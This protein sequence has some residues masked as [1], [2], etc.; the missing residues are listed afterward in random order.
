[1]S[2]KYQL[3]NGLTVILNESHKSPVVSVQMWV[4]TGSA[5]EGK[6]EEGISHFIE[7]LVFKGTEKFGVGEIASAVE[8]SGGELNA[9]TSFDQTVFYVTISKAFTDT[10]LEVISQMMGFPTFVQEEIDNEREVVIEEIKRGFDSAGRCSSQLLFSTAYKKHP[11]SIPV[12]GY[13]KNIRKVS[14]KTLLDYFHSRYVPQNMFLVVSGD[15]EKAE[16][17][18]KVKEYFGCFDQ[19]PLRRVK[20]KKE[21]VQESPRVAVQES[22]F[23]ESHVYLGWKLPTIKHKDMPALD[24]LALILGQGESSRL[25]RRL[26]LETPLVN[27]VYSSAF[28]TKEKGLFVVGAALNHKNLEEFFDILAEE[29]TR[30]CSESVSGQE[31]EKAVTNI[32]AEEFYGMETAEGLSRQLGNLEMLMGD[33]K[34]FPKYM[35]EVYGVTS[36]DV[37]KAAKKYLKIENLTLT[38]LASEGNKKEEVKK[39]ART[40]IKKLKKK[41]KSQKRKA[42]EKASKTKRKKRS[43]KS[44]Q[45]G[46]KEKME[47][48]KLSSGSTLVLKPSQETLCFSARSA[49]LGGA[50]IEQPETAGLTELLSRTWAAGTNLYSEKEIHHKMDDWASAMHAF[51]GRNTIGMSMDGLKTFEKELVELYANVLTQ[52]M[53]PEEI[54][55][56][57][58]T[59]MKEMIKVRDDNPAQKAI[60]KFMQELFL[61]HPYSRDPKGSIETLEGLDREKVVSHWKKMSMSSNFIT[62]V[63][64]NIDADLWKEK[65]GEVVKNLSP[66]EFE[67]KKFA[68]AA[69]AEDVFRYVPLEKQQTHI[70]TGVKGLTFESK[71]RHALDLI[72]ALLSGQGG[73]LFI[74]LRDKKSLAYSVSPLKMEGIDSGYFGAYIGCSPEKGTEAISMLHQELKKLATE[75]VPEKELLRSKR[76]LIGNHDIDLQRNSAIAN[77]ILFDE[78]YGLDINET[79]N[80]QKEI[81]EVTADQVRDLAEELFSQKFVTVAVGAEQPF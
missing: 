57:E 42:G 38:V 11:Y 33:H 6:G 81:N 66:G 60:L 69:P 29:V 17:K 76:Y 54:V 26:R 44:S 36:E 65:I 75:K 63:S 59:V 40:A 16:M 5:D 62:V 56:R 10:A 24:I 72:Q 64:G 4:R 74:E 78:I 7:H 15:F 28:K 12:I 18:K 68:H 47:V 21:D 48:I 70:V 3:P 9:Y 49:H 67:K 39:L 32:E 46:S 58:K 2:T 50:R 55:D 34:Y 43:F 52:P 22:Q 20:R 25:T 27:Y 61:E 31:L 19:H 71:K 14:R 51:G 8:G 1:M 13:E 23:E 45:A 80:Y 41:S 77:S 53:F 37:Q 73:R 79:F 35:K 30:I